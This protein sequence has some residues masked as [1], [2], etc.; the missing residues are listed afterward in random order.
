[1]KT[2]ILFGH[3]AF[4]KSTVNKE[5]IRGLLEL[6][7]VTFHDLYENYPDMDIDIDY[8]QKLLSEHDCIIM[9]HPFY[10]YSTPAIF[11]EW[12]DLVL[13]HGWAFGSE[14]THLE[15]K[16]FFS[17][18]T[19]GAPKAVYARGQRQNYTIN[20]LLAPVFQTSNLCNMI[21][22][23][24][25]VTHGSHSIDMKYISRNRGLFFKLLEHISNDMLD[26]N[27]AREYEYINYYIREV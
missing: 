26:V 27:K 14:G 13:E 22:L 2:L 24:P 12:M 5:L 10:W 8:E 25:F 11:K 7:Y 1:M 16:L 18:I 17:A 3:P 4:Q 9:M 20:E 6:E 21:T 19:T 23:P 15:G